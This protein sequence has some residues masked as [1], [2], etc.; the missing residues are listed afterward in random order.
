MYIKTTE[1]QEERREKFGDIVLH[2]HLIVGFSGYTDFDKSAL[3]TVR[4]YW[5]YGNFHVESVTSARM[6]IK[7]IMKYIQK[8]LDSP[9]L[10]LFGNM[11]RI[12]MS[13]LPMYFRLQWRYLMGMI[14]HFS[15]DWEY[16]TKEMKFDKLGVYFTTGFKNAWGRLHKKEYL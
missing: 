14:V 3:D 1:V 12:T 6:G 10:D 11:R 2:W 9:V 4:N 15:C 5:E 16:I 8:S 13:R 7:Y